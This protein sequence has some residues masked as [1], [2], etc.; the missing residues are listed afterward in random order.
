MTLSGTLKLLHLKEKKFGSLLNVALSL[1]RYRENSD[2]QILSAS[3]AF[4]LPAVNSKARI[5]WGTVFIREMFNFFE[6][7]D[8]E[9]GPN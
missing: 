3:D 6:V 8:D 9:N 1:K 7:A 4:H 5:T 2:I